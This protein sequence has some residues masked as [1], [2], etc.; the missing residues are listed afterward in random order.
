MYSITTPCGWKAVSWK[1]MWRLLTAAVMAP[2]LLRP[3][4][5]VLCRRGLRICQ[6]CAMR[7]TW[8]PCLTSVADKAFILKLVLFLIVY[9]RKLRTLLYCKSWEALTQI[10]LLKKP[11]QCRRSLQLS[12]SQLLVK[13]TCRTML[14]AANLAHPLLLHLKKGS[15]KRQPFTSE[16][17]FQLIIIT[18]LKQRTRRKIDLSFNVYSFSIYNLKQILLALQKKYF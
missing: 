1:W 15:F 12:S 10:V 13:C 3:L 17:L 6:T 7:K 4:P 11:L 14:S 5:G 18:L 2:S 9:K 8:V 16:V